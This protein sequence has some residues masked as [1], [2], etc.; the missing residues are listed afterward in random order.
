[1]FL[2]ATDL[3]FCTSEMFD[4]FEMFQ[5]MVDNT[6]LFPWSIFTPKG[7]EKQNNSQIFSGFPR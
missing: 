3:H 4:K 5:S 2:P 7:K 1:M 6:I